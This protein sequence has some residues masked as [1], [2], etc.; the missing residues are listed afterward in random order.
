MAP[1]GILVAA[2]PEAAA[3][4]TELRAQVGHSAEG[5]PSTA[6]RFTAA[7]AS[8]AAEASAERCAAGWQHPGAL[9]A[10]VEPQPMDVSRY[11]YR[12]NA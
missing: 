12:H 10:A 3:P 2:A 1:A 9:A 6:A 7:A 4:R 5:P 11:D 8:R